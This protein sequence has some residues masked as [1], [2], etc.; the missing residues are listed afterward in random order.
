MGHPRGASGG[1][2]SKQGIRPAGLPG[3]DDAH[4]QARAGELSKGLLTAEPAAGWGAAG[5]RL[6]HE[7]CVGG[8]RRR[9]G[10]VQI[11]ATQQ[12]KPYV[13]TA[14]RRLAFS[15]ARA[16]LRNPPPTLRSNSFCFICHRNPSWVRRWPH[17]SRLPHPAQLRS[18]ADS[19]GVWGTGKREKMR[20]P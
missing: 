14:P 17:R 1:L 11:V 8:R 7:A 20:S 10:P 3:P 16:V 5:P 18:A 12:W 6:A 2:T 13:E 15:N 4:G 19:Q 9:R